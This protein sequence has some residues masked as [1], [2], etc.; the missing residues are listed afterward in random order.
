MTR[1]DSTQDTM[2]HIGKV[3]QRISECVNSLNFRAKVHDAS[4]LLPPEKQAF[5]EAT[6]LLHGM[7]YG[8]DEYKASIAKLGPALAHHYFVN[9]HHPEHYPDGIAG[10]SLLDLLEMLCDWK[11]AT[12]RHADGDLERSIEIN[13]A[14]FGISDQLASIL[15]NT[16]REMEW[17]EQPEVQP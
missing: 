7:T 15:R 14:R 12:E 11:A 4:K 8:S 3:R 6:P 1:Y 13:R 10:M 9:S 17:I 2:E 5:D 16:A